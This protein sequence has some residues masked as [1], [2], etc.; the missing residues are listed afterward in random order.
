M[1]TQV[2]TDDLSG[3]AELIRSGGLVAVPTETVYGLAGNGLDAAAVE[4]IYE[5]KGRPAVKPLSLM[6]SGKDEMCRYAAEVPDAAGYRA[7]KYW[8]GPLTIVLKAKDAIPDIVLAGGK[9]VGLRCPDH[10]LTLQ[11]I[12]E[13]GTAL[14]APSAN[15]SGGKSPVCAADVLAVF[16]GQIEA[17]IDGGPCAL[18]IESTLIDLSAKPYRVLRAGAVS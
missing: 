10:P 8:P 11:L 5:V 15:L 17:V 3:A 4:K 18:K 1:K 9:T 12:R 13:S 6:V 16:D 14:A 7:E 2:F